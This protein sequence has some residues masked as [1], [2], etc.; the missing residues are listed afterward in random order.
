LNVHLRVTFTYNFLANH[1]DKSCLKWNETALP[2]KGG[3]QESSSLTPHASSRQ[4][5][6]TQWLPFARGG[7]GWGK[8]LINQLFQTCVYTVGRGAVGT[9]VAEKVKL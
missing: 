4:S 9:E 7:L 6:P 2:C 5:R 1:L 3:K 8:T